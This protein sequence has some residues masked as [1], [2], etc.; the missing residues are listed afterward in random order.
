MTETTTVG[1]LDGGVL[2][3]GGADRVDLL[4]RISTNDLTALRQIGRSRDTVF[5]TNQGKMIDWVALVS[6]PDA[7]LLRT[8]AGRAPRL[9]EWIERYTITEEV[10][11]T[12]DS[13]AWSVV[14]LSGP[15]GAAAIGIDA[16]D[17]GVAVERD[18]AWWYRANPAY[19]TRI[20]GLVPRARAAAVVE[21]ARGAGAVRIDASALEASRL[22]AGVPSPDFE[23]EDE[24]N[25]LELRLK[26]S[27]DFHKGCYIGQ[28]VIARMDSY[29]K[30]ARYLIGL[31]ADADID[32]ARAAKLRRDDRPL[33]RVTS[34]QRSPGGIL[35]L[36]V[37]KREAAC[38]GE[39]EVT[40]EDGAP[41][42]TVRLV[43][44]PFWTSAA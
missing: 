37:V 14:V 24:V 23:F 8:S 21:A 17:A 7:L 20:D 13:A 31:E 11:T 4:H 43:D 28:E 41:L 30:V 12:V 27:V 42:G 6:A 25:P 18:G 36:A 3:V 32:V 22:R 19:G 15:G 38:A 10:T 29:E 39:A 33:G 35:G 9:A 26:S 40:T 44:R 34:M 5:T 2:R 16:P 1:L